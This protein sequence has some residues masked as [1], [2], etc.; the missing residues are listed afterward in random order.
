MSYTR[1]IDDGPYQYP[2][3]STHNA[4]ARPYSSEPIY[5]GHA[6]VASG[7]R[8]YT[9]QWWYDERGDG[10]YQTSGEDRVCM[11]ASTYN[12]LT[13]GGRDARD[14]RDRDY[15]VL[16]DPLYPALDRTRMRNYEGIQKRHFNLPTQYSDD[17]YRLVGY[18]VNNASSTPTWKLMGRLVDR[19]RGDFYMI[20]ANGT[21][22]K[23]PISNG[24]IVGR[25]KLT[26]FY[27]IPDTLTFSSPLLEASPY[28]YVPL[29]RSDLQDMRY[30]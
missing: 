12:R 7:N 21:E 26:D 29:P 30:V 15:R 28:T 16:Y 24:M 10:I 20:P 4:T 6:S 2:L 11:N 23:V 9:R 8:P 14:A 22:I 17:T 13:M 19:H 25:E 3:P 18:L 27:T 5:D 1:P